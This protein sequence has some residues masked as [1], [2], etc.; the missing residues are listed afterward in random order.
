MS[1]VMRDM[2]TPAFSSVK[3]L[4]DRRWRWAKIFT[5]RSFITQAANRPVTWALNR[6]ARA[7]MAMNT[8]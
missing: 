3:K 5:R 4:R 6:W 2:T 1:L 7:V 8:R